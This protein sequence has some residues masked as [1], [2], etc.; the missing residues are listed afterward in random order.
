MLKDA[1]LKIIRDVSQRYQVRRVLL[2][3]SSLD[4]DDNARDID[5]AVEGVPPEAF[6]E[7]YGDLMMQLPRP[8]D[9]VD[10]SSPSKFS[11]LI[12]RDGVAIYG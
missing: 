5:I 2:F 11:E 7:Y 9:V 4:A 10:L 6:F 8:V 12:L 3:G 1:E